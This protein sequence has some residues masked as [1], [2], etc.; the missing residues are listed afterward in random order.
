MRVAVDARY[1]M[2]PG[3][4]ISVY[5]RDFITELAAGDDDV[6]L[7]T[8]AESHAAA[9]AAEFPRCSSTALVQRRRTVWE[10][11]E[12]PRWLAGAEPDVLIAGA[13]RGL[14]LRRASPTTSNVLILHD[15]IPLRMGREYLLGDPLSA[16]RYL[17]DT[18]VSLARADLFVVNSRSTADDL[19]RLCP[20]ARVAVRY[21]GF[22]SSPASASAP[23]A[24]WPERYFLYCGGAD[25]RKNVAQLLEAFYAYRRAGGENALVV[26]GSGFD[27]LRAGNESPHTFF[28]GY[29][30]DAVK[31][32]AIAHAQAVVYPSR[33]EG[34]G[35]PI[36]EALAFG[37]PVL[38]GGG[39]AQTEVGGEA[40][41]YVDVHDVASIADG[42]RRVSAAPWRDAVRRTAP[43]QVERLR[44]GRIPAS[45]IIAEAVRAR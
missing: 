36:A 24:G 33:F 7:L 13:N 3:V 14:P 6:T 5:L 43:E 35:L 18:A 44:R 8:S 19:R 29:V 11:V 4:G 17:F 26:I 41:L 10:Q 32:A 38:A 40:A 25:A 9:L 12:L 22:D 2:R 42:L 34:F 30:D 15:L 1:L 21:P 45:G 28:T 39:G 31:T 27:R 16:W 37:V 23:P 20:R